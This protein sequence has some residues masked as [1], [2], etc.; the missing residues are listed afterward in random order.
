MKILIVTGI[1][2][3]EIGGPAPYAANL[4][5]KLIQ[6]GHIVD[7]ITYSDLET[8]EGDLKYPFHVTRV[9]RQGKLSN[10]ARMFWLLFRNIKKYNVVYSLDWFSV[11]VPL[12]L[13]SYLKRKRYIVRVGGGYLW[14]R[15]LAE[16]NPP[17]PM[18]AFYEKLLFKKYP[19]MYFL[20]RQVLR[21]AAYVVFNS[22]TQAELYNRYYEINPESIRVIYNPVT[23][24]LIPVS[25]T[26]PTKEIFFVGRFIAMKNIES[27]LRAFAKLKDTTYTLSLIGEGPRAELLLGLTK[28][29]GIADRVTWSGPLPQ[30]ELYTRIINC[31][32][33]VLPSWTDISPNQIYECMAL[34][35]PFLLTKEN[36]LAINEEEFLKIDPTNV[37]DIAEKMN[38]L[39]D[40]KM[41]GPFTQ[42]LK[43]IDF[44]Y[45]W[46]EA[47]KDH[48]RLFNT[49]V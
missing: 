1:F 46:D 36:Y 38:L 11:G 43:Q 24:V 22:Q 8:Y 35:I 6:A 47:V 26:A 27:L 9:L 14:E 16:N 49:L 2:P 12:Y 39:S 18:R 20:I 17:M 3:P 13:A 32:Y 30:E 15:Y 33:V 45:T 23:K 19:I 41:Y 25:R 5:T 37:D 21:N 31:A 48:M 34:G 40:P 4:A 44:S 28:E 29:L 10:Y 7:L 42:E